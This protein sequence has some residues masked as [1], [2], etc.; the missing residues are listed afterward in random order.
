[1]MTTLARPGR[2]GRPVDRRRTGTAVDGG[3]R[4]VDGSR[5]LKPPKGF[6]AAAVVP[7]VLSSVIVTIV[8][9]SRY[10][11]GVS[12][13][14]RC[15]SCGMTSRPIELERGGVGD[16]RATLMM[17]CSAP[18]S[19]SSPKRST[20]W[21]GVSVA[22]DRLEI[23]R[24]G[25][26]SARSRPGRGRPPRSARPRIAYLRAMPSGDAED[27][28]GVGVLGHEAQRLL[29]AAAT[30]HDRDPGARQRLRGVEQ[31]RRPGTA[32]RGTPP[33]EPRSPC[34]IPWA[35]WSVSS[36]ISNRSPSGGNGNPSASRLL[37]V[38]GGADAEPGPAA[39]QDVERRRR[40][41]PQARVAVVDATDHQPE[42]G[43]AAC[44]RP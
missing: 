31:P 19:D 40:L 28:A 20:T 1:M 44:A 2:R 12:S 32:G 34:H 25:G 39:R 21:L 10:P 23:G 27:V 18:A 6:V 26:S 43:V 16:V 5:S 8:A 13:S 17:T 14:A 30:D 29:L 36:S 7:L 41:H 37:L 15:P 22:S 42:P 3:R 4:V 11:W 9:W 24:S 33:R 35:I 38:P